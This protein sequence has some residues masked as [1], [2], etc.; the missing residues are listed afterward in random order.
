MTIQ[1]NF[2]LFPNVLGLGDL[3]QV[4]VKS[5][6]VTKWY[7]H[8]TQFPLHLRVKSL[9]ILSNFCIKPIPAS[10]N[11]RLTYY[12]KTSFESGSLI[13]ISCTLLP[14][15]SFHLL[16]WPE[17]ALADLWHTCRLLLLGN[18]GMTRAILSRCGRLVHCLYAQNIYV[19]CI[20]M[21]NSRQVFDNV[22]SGRVLQSQ[23]VE[24]KQ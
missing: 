2:G 9:L 12:T 17:F 22:V 20:L 16:V 1:N 10:S 18:Y 4:P 5:N 6:L 14:C 11:C 7:N 8:S 21:H 19:V 24:Y 15:S 23:S 13:C 3:Y